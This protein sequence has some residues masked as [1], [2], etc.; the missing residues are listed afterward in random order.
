[1][2]C[3]IT[4]VAL[5]LA[6]ASAAD[7]LRM[8]IHN[9]CNQQIWMESLNNPDHAP[10]ADGI[11]HL[12]PG[13][14]HDY[15]FPNGVWAGRFWAKVGCDVFGRNCSSG[16]SMEPCPP[17][18]CQAP[19]D[20]KIEFNFQNGDGKSASTVTWYDISLVDGY[21]LA[22]KIQPRGAESG[23]CVTSL[24]NLDFNLCPQEEIAGL[25]DLRMRDSDG[26]VVQCLSP[27]KKWNWPQPLG[28]GRDEAVA[29]GDK[30]CCPAHLTADQ[31]RA[32]VEQTRFVEVVRRTCPTAYSWAYDDDAG[33]HTCPP[34]TVF[35]V[36]ICP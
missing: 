11:V 12:L 22:C 6:L 35:D 34:D 19:G 5:L 13:E 21:G 29:P 10:H 14:S 3:K 15:T 25:G 17:G 7:L 23:T 8:N 9:A 32:E 1:M 36:T 31:C 18:G 2:G 28:L 26:N 16:Q 30:F 24:C 4:L 20:T 27:C 33:L